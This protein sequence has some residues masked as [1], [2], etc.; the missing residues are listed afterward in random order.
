MQIKHVISICYFEILPYDDTL[1]H[2][3]ICHIVF[4]LIPQSWNS[5]QQTV[6]CN[7][8]HMSSFMVTIFDTEFMSRHITCNLYYNLKFVPIHF[9]GQLFHRNM[10]FNENWHL[11]FRC[12][13]L[14]TW[15][16]RPVNMTEATL[17]VNNYMYIDICSISAKFHMCMYDKN[18]ND[19]AQNQ[20]NIHCSCVHNRTFWTTLKKYR[21]LFSKPTLWPFSAVSKGC[22]QAILCIP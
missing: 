4:I 3:V 15:K 20:S 17:N 6:F 1:A 13:F 21:V 8:W 7:V 19:Y 16:Y 11:L 22:P 12:L 5:H 10:T 18:K 2:L 9:F 14:F